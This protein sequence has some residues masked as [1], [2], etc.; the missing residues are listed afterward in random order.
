LEEETCSFLVKPMK[1]Q[2]ELLSQIQVASPCTADWN[3]MKGDD[4]VRFCG[5]CSKNVYN[6]SALTADAAINLVREHE[7]NLCGRFFRRADGTV[8]T[9]D[10]PV[11]VHHRI[12]RKRKLAVLATSL[13]SLFGFSGCAKFD[14]PTSATTGTSTGN[15]V[16]ANV[17][18]P[19]S[20]QPEDRPLLQGGA[21]MGKICPPDDFRPIAQPVGEATDK[22]PPPR[23]L[24]SE[25]LPK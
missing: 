23:E 20:E 15:E 16:N 24:E 4:F 3:E 21:V 6:L 1:T 19:N 12:R 5:E 2:L 25:V 18:R 14:E 22:L 17:N 10:C 13:F 11:G 7:G 9:G 8:L